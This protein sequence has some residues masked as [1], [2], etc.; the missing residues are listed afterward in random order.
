MPTKK[1]DHRDPT[2]Q[3]K[4]EGRFLFFHFNASGLAAVA[5]V[6]LGLILATAMAILT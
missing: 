2:H 5:V 1:P 4:I 6:A 3:P